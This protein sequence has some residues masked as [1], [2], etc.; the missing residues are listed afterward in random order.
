MTHKRAGAAGRRLAAFMISLAALGAAVAQSP[1]TNLKAVPKTLMPV[2]ET[3]LAFAA[4]ARARGVRDS[5]IEYAAE[6][7]LLFRRTAVN[8]REFWRKATPAPTGLLS[9]YPTYADVSRAGDVGWTTGPWEFREKP[10]DREASGHG[11]FVTVWRRQADGTFR[12]AL[13]MGVRHSAPATPETTLTFPD[14]AKRGGPGGSEKEAETARAAIVAAEAEI[15]AASAA[16]GSGRA[17]L[18]RASEDLRLY[19]QDAT[20]FVGKAAAAPALEKETSRLTFRLAGAG[21]SRSADL[22]Y[23][24]GTYE[25]GGDAPGGHY[26]RIWKRQGGRWQIVLEVTNPIPPPPKSN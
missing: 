14:S 4:A 1:L 3:E 26:M 22:G 23:T 18:A 7:G 2:V 19:R 5:F 9:W 8:A 6:D 10:D 15:A 21:A 16:T 17:V 24:Y 13:D 11:H 25:A 12:F 20:P